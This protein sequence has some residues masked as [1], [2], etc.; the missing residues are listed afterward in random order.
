MKNE[1]FF[2]A[3]SNDNL[4]TNFERKSMLGFKLKVWLELNIGI[5]LME[6]YMYWFI[7]LYIYGSDLKYW[8]VKSINDT[9]IVV[10]GYF[11]LFLV[12][13]KI[14]FPS[15]YFPWFDF[16]T[17]NLLTSF[18]YQFI[19]WWYNFKPNLFCHGWFITGKSFSR[20]NYLTMHK[21]S[22]NNV[23]PHTC[24]VCGKNFISRIAMKNHKAKNG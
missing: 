15:Y 12:F 19:R 2:F 7:Y 17:R 14:D 22:H 1:Y 16:Y 21:N 20:S 6:L 3:I 9:N 5:G 10:V 18:I 13:L 11:P 8:K 4:L 23:R 24:D